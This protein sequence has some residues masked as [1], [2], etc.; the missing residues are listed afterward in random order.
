MSG[1]DA[2]KERAAASKLEQVARPE[3]KGW[4]LAPGIYGP[5]ATAALVSGATCDISSP[6]LNPLPPP[7]WRH[8][9]G[10]TVPKKNF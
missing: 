5:A 4:R 6:S 8:L 1:A 7:F 2:Q 9:M 10:S 3:E